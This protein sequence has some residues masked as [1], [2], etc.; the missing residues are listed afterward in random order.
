[1]ATTNLCSSRHLPPHLPLSPHGVVRRTRRLHSRALHVD[2]SLC[3]LSPLRRIV[4]EL[5]VGA[6]IRWT[7]DWGGTMLVG[8]RLRNNVICF[9]T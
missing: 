9:T 8:R 2:V 5:A 3:Y 7:T 6:S 1:M 4:P